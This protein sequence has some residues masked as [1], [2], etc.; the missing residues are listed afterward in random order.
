MAAP[1][2]SGRQD[3]STT[4]LEPPGGSRR[5]RA[6]E[7]RGGGGLTSGCRDVSELSVPKTQM[8]GD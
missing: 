8:I 2:I 5:L 6:E 1:A 4:L 7:E 3:L